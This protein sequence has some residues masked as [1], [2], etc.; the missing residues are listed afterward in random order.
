MN[1]IDYRD[2]CAGTILGTAFGDA[3]GAAVEGW[4]A[5]EIRSEHGEIRDFLE[6]RG[7][8]GRYTDDTQMMLGMARSLVR[9]GKIDGADC[10][11]SCAELFAPERGYGRSATRILMALETGADYRETATVLF[12]EGS[13]G[14]GA[15]MRIAPVGLLSGSKEPKLLRP[16][17]VEA[18]RATHVHDEAI[19]GALVVAAAVGIL[20]RMRVFSEVN[21]PGF[22]FELSPYCR[23]MEMRSRMMLASR[24]LEEKPSR[25]EVVARLGNGVRTL[26]SVPT[27]LYTAMRFI[28]EPEEALVAAVGYGGDAD[29]IAAM[30]GAVVGACHG[31]SAFPQRWHEQLE[32]GADGYDALCEVS[33]QLAN[34]IK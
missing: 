19:D 31:A 28:S 26:E 3:L 33:R 13:F 10:A 14:N 15:A 2:R 21:G 24:L 17:V 18:V 29:T 25:D 34:L 12:P 1:A 23:T 20:S 22:L 8:A 16:W 9:I 5:D 27:A 32:R 6:G 7:G 11:R 30:T 4:T